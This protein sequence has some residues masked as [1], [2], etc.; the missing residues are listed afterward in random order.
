MTKVGTIKPQDMRQSSGDFIRYLPIN[1]ALFASPLFITSA[2]RASIQPG[3]A[4]P[5]QGHPD[6]YQFRWE[7][8]RVLPD[9]SLLWVESGSGIWETRHGS[10]PIQADQVGRVISGQ[11]HRYRPSPT[12]GWTECWVHFNGPLAHELEK[13]GLFPPTLP[14]STPH[15][16]QRFARHFRELLTDLASPEFLNNASQ[17]LRLLGLLGLLDPHQGP[18]PAPGHDLVE[19]ARRHIWSHSHRQLNVAEVAVH[20][21]VSRRTLE[22]AFA[23]RGLPGVLDEIT[24]CRLNRAERLLRET[25]L[26]VQHIVSLSGFGTNEQMRLHFHTRHGISPGAYRKAAADPPQR[27]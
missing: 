10:L 23:G 17:G 14:V 26:S 18:A 4:Y 5:P 6:L 15:H 2:G 21:G 27:S 24:R 9:F 22:R 8:G 16:P 13:S 20:L 1:E 19:Q 11:W 7:E 25:R 3:A 12:T